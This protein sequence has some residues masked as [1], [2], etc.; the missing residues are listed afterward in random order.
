MN[1]PVAK[2]DVIL[3]KS[4]FKGYGWLTENGKSW[5]DY[6]AAFRKYRHALYVTNVSKERPQGF[7]QLNY[8]FLTTLSMTGEEFRPG[9]YRTAG[10]TAR[11]TT[12]AVAD[13]GHGDRILQAAGGR[14]LPPPGV[15]PAGRLV[16]SRPE[17]PGLPSG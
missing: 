17:K 10:S 15:H 7:T 2:V 14:S 13:Q 9:T 8:Q 12:P 3:T 4:M 6:W 16:G 5:E 1:H 11:R